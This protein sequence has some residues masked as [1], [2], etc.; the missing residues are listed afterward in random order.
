MACRC[1]IYGF[2]CPI[3]SSHKNR[4]R[5]QSFIALQRFYYML[6]YVPM[7]LENK[8]NCRLRPIDSIKDDLQTHMVNVKMID[9]A[10]IFANEAYFLDFATALNNEGQADLYM[11]HF[12]KIMTQVYWSY[13]KW[14]IFWSIFV[15][16]V[17]YL[18]IS[19]FYPQ[20]SIIFE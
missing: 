14:L 6:G 1:K 17:L 7:R 12:V 8:K 2:L 20:R 15:P 10:W 19:I 9:I 13:N 3:L 16:Y 5:R 4:L 18:V 11:T